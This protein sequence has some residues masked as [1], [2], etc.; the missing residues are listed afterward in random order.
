MLYQGLAKFHRQLKQPIAGLTLL[1]LVAI[2]SPPI[3][4]AQTPIQ[5]TPTAP[6]SGQAQV[7]NSYILGAGDRIRIDVFRVEQFSGENEVLIDGTLNLP[8]IGAVQVEGLTLE[9]AANAISSRYSRLLR[10]PLVTV[11]L[12]APRPLEIGIAGEVERPGSYAVP[13][14]NAQF[15]TLTQVLQAA[16]GI[17]LSANLRQVQVRRMQ[18]QGAEQVLTVN[19]WQLIQTGDPRYDLVL[20]DGDNIFIPTAETISLEETSQIAAA[21]F[22]ASFNQP[23]NVAV[24]GEVFRPGPYTLTGG[25]PRTGEAGVPG[26]GQSGGNLSTV[27]QAIQRAGGI[28]PLADIRNIQIRR[29]TRTGTEQV[30]NINLQELIASGDLRQDIIL[31]EGDTISVP[32]AAD[33]TPEEA[34]QI[35]SASFSPDT[36]RV[37]VVGEVDSPGIIEVP[38]NTPLNQALLAAGGFNTRA[39]RGE[40]NLVRLNP[41]GTVSEREVPVDF[42]QGINEESNPIL[43]NNDVLVVGRSGIAATSDTLDTVLRPLGSFFSILS[44]PFRIFG[45]FD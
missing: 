32:L 11:S 20:R 7:P 24:V 14:Q 1:S 4:A 2:A 27:T 26:S 21:S 39:R 36:I 6:A 12:L 9:Q 42:A 40:V 45:L 33:I 28:K 3:A 15:P 37:N 22:F 8:Q 35:A 30:I 38:P 19:L 31:Q 13:V 25:T 44:L 43:R 16:G 23:I 17:R 41:N 10:R 29:P 18:G 5:I 34:T